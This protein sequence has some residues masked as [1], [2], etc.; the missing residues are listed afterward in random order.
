VQIDIK[1]TDIKPIRQTY[2]HIARRI[3]E[4]KPA[5]RYQE[6]TLDVQQTVN[7]HY[8]PTWDPAHELFDASR[9]KI[10]MEDWYSFKDPRQYYY[11]TYTI[12]RSKQQ[13][14]TEAN[15][16]FVEK[17]GLL[18]NLDDAQRKRITDLLVP[19][20]HVAWGANMNNIS[21]TDLGYGTAITAPASFHAMD[22]LGIAQYLSRIGLTF[23]GPEL[24]D[25]AK[26]QWM[27]DAT[28]QPMRKLLEDS[29]VLEDWFEVFVF[30]NLVLDGM[31]Y[32]LVYDT[33][34]DGVF[35]SD[36]GAGTAMLTQFM[37]DWFSESTRWVDAQLKIA[38]GES[39]AN[40]TLI[41][42]WIKDYLP[43]V[44]QAI[45]PIA[46]MTLGD[47]A[48]AAMAEVETQLGARI[49]KLGFNIGD[50]A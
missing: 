47:D 29:F 11:G 5:S 22:Q 24:L 13:D 33:I 32:P 48:G 7:F 41:E 35:A 34:V 17:K 50:S 37:S 49:K 25:A 2:S 14:T 21:I 9:T 43:R 39:D 6:A 16:K 8:R 45:E 44:R 27:E 1:T 4:G 3:G 46:I 31:L 28:W 18:D 26:T 40:R 38:S 36:G 42:G 12:T 15:F 10:V 20:R 19:L 30:Q 23:G